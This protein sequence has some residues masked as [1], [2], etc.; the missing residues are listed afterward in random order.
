MP[1]SRA[2]GSKTS[3]R[4]SANPYRLDRNV[5]PQSYDL[6]IEPDLAQFKFEGRA[7]IWIKAA[8]SFTSITLHAVEL[9]IQHAALMT[10][11]GVRV[12]SR[13]VRFDKKMETVTIEF[14]RS[15]TPQETGTL[16][17]EFTGTLN[18][19]MHGFYRTSYDYLGKKTWGAATQFEATDARRAFPCWDEPDMKAT[20][21]VTLRVPKE[22]TALSNMPVKQITASGNKKEITYET[23]PIM[24]TYLLCFVVA[25]LEGI[26]AKDKNGVEIGVWTTPGKAPHGRFGLEVAKFC[27][28][29]FADWFGIPYSL[30]KLDMVAL[31]D[32]SSGAMENWGLVTYRETALLVDPKNSSVAARQRVAEVIDHELAHQWFGNLVTMEWWTDLWLNEGFA[33]Y[34]GPKAVDAQFPQWRIWTQFLA[35]EYLAALRDDSLRNTHAIEIDVK[36]PAEI[37]EIFDHITYAKGSSVNRML[38]HYLT[39]PALRKG[40]KNYL[41]QYAFR[42]AR[43]VDLWKALEEASGKP[44]RAV[45]AS[46]TRQGGYPV[47][48]V[49][50]SAPGVSKRRKLRLTQSRFLFDGSKDAANPLWQVPVTAAVQ[51]SSK[52]FETLLNKKTGALTVEA[53]AGRWIKVNPG[54]SGF[55]RV[56]YTPGLIAP[57]AA[58]LKRGDFAPE[59]ALGLLDDAFVLARAGRMRTSQVM[60]LL[61]GCEQEMDYNVWSTIAGILGQVEELAHGDTRHRFNIWSREL[62]AWTHERLGWESKP[63]DNHLDVMLRAMV[64]GRLGHYGYEPV[65]EGAVKRLSAFSKG[66]PLDPNIRGAVYATAAA[67]GD[68]KTH[69]ALMKIFA[70]STLQE[71]KVRVL[72]SLT[73]FRDKSVAAEVLKFALSDGVRSQDRYVLL[74]GFGSNA[75]CREQAWE[76]V[77]REWKTVTSFFSGGNLGMMTRIIEGSTQGFRTESHAKDVQS[78]FKAHPVQGAQRAVQQSIEVIRANAR[79]EARDRADLSAWLSKVR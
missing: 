43:T 5:L 8:K 49:D 60:E 37:R 1:K 71:E 19:Q 4:P 13:S 70:Q 78:F 27:L 36:D 28:P 20:F 44:V 58:G 29:Y 76:F 14:G 54:Q 9:E 72:R 18:D 57:L 24:S 39:E 30:P 74:G 31:P 69:S 41:K 77:K 67:H 2:L 33:S 15:F 52:R 73:R 25:H 61:A 62:F 68:A 38:E 26:F 66:G 21:K 48:T 16:E 65:I 23:T 55:Y 53:G 47:I 35:T 51:G 32:F 46:Y 45:M 7:S 50:A 63:K 3:A 42:N 59:D 34:M 22:L 79:W 40:L 17:L 6:W 12:G 56:A 10:V 11:E 64:I 75:A